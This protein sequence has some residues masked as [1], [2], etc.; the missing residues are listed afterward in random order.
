MANPPGK[1][2]NYY[3]EERKMREGKHPE[4][5]CIQEIQEGARPYQPA[6]GLRAP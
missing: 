3:F 5:L 6:L 1:Q 4:P 2:L